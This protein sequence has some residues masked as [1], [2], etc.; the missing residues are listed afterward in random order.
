MDSILEPLVNSPLFPRYVEQLQEITRTE[1]ERRERFY[2]EIAP[3]AKWEFINGEV[4]MHSPATVKHTAVRERLVRLVGTYVDLKQLG[5]AGGEKVLIALTRNDYE[6][7]IVFFSRAKMS[8]IVPE[9]SK[10][11]APDFVIEVLSPSTMRL[12]RGF[13]YADYAAPGIGEYWIVDPAA[14]VIEQHLLGPNG[15][16]LAA[17]QADG[18]IHS[19]VIAGFTL[20]VRAAFDH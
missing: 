19:R 6:P 10:L 18:T 9:Q 20:P 3:D 7:D 14:E 15:Y 17:K 5:W 8:T 11:P 2:E 12:D 1:R 16:E 4:F 13:K